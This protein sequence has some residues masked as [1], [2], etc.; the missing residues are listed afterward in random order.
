MIIKATVKGK[1]IEIDIPASDY[2][3]E[4]NK[5]RITPYWNNADNLEKRMNKEFEKVYKELEKELYTFVGKFG[6]DNKLTYSQKRIVSLMKEIK[7]YIDDLY[8]YHQ[9]SLTD[10]LMETYK[11][12]YF[13]GLYDLTIGT[14]VAYSFVGINETA[15]KTAINYPWSGE[16]FS[17]RIYNNKNNLIRSLRT[18]L[19]QSI[20]RGDS[21]KDT[22]KIV[23]NRLGISRKNAGRLVQTE[24]GAVLTT[25]D[26]KMYED[27]GLD[28]YEY[29]A[30]LDDRTSAICKELDNKVFKVEDMTIGV[31]ASP[32]HPRCRS[33]Q[34]PFFSDNTTK[35]MARDLSIGKSVVIDDMS[36]KEWENTY[37]D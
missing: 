24:V 32:M 34:V 15:I 2:W 21:I 9:L 28:E 18:D 10:L 17:D 29:V 3:I 13:K 6:T 27:F 8:D 26:K 11:D 5:Q 30:T 37:V 25:S 19:T 36:Y 14:K 12:N 35:R 16:N 7:P 22:T 4:R 33:T 31:N 1:E 23:A 20:I